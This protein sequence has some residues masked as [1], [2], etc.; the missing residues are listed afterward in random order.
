[1]DI[2]TLSTPALVITE[3]RLRANI[4]RWQALANHYGVTLRPHI[5]THKSL[6]IAR[7]QIAAGAGGITSAK[8]SEA[9]VFIDAGFTD[10]FVAYPIIGADK[11]AH[12][13][14]LAL[15]CRL[16]V[17][18]D[19]LVGIA[20]L[21]AAMQSVDAT[22]GVRVEIDTG[23]HRCGVAPHA[24]AELCRAVLAAP[25]L[26]L[27]GIF[28]YRGA[29]FAGSN[30]RA[31]DELGIEESQM[32]V[33]VANDLRALGIAINAISV[34]STPTGAGAVQVPGITEVRPGT[35]VFGDDM[36]LR[37]GACTVDQVGL[38]IWCTVISRP[39][40]QTATIDAGSKTFSGDVVPD[41]LGLLGYAT[42]VDYAATLV[43]MSEEHGVLQ[44]AD[45]VDLP[46][47]TRIAM[48]PIHVCTT[49]NL[50]DTMYLQGADGDCT[51][52]QVVARGKR[53]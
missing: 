16:I 13:A 46:I 3:S 45:G 39:D 49:V 53:S 4:T 20:Q 6:E 7:M 15:R 48:R 52:I 43:R 33:A 2:T 29:W 25:G 11:C 5:K 36:Q 23:L 30:G 42:A 24:A 14:Q 31:G 50:S 35:Y 37:N 32:M 38:A 44:L 9:E 17:G 34:G 40:A 18:V 51:P 8:L 1:M 41:R 26:I 19:S 28:T 10:C 47:G 12:A 21:S 27:D 22:V